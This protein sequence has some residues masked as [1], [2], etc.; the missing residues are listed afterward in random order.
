MIIHRN[1]SLVMFLSY[2]QLQRA[3]EILVIVAFPMSLKAKELQAKMLLNHFE[4]DWRVSA[5]EQQ[6]TKFLFL[7]GRRSKEDLYIL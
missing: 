3:V 1:V 7:S 2:C 4:L 5:K 6:L